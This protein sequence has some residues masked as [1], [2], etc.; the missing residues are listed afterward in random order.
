MTVKK[1]A[2]EMVVALEKLVGEARQ[3][4]ANLRLSGADLAADMLE[5]TI[6][7]LVEDKAACEKLAAEEQ[8]AEDE[9]EKNPEPGRWEPWMGEFDETV[10]VHFDQ[11]GRE[12]YLVGNGARLFFVDERQGGRATEFEKKT[13]DEIIR[14]VIGGDEI[15][16]QYRGKYTKERVASMMRR[17]EKMRNGGRPRLEVVK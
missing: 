8:D 4:E 13:S 6:E 12:T 7:G 16:N 3:M 10:V 9:E 17:Y 14:I 2:K 11:G 15:E 5:K 1:A